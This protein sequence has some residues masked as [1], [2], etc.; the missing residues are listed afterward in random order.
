[1]VPSFI[2]IQDIQEI[3]LGNE[4]GNEFAFCT[5]IYFFGQ[6]LKRRQERKNKTTQ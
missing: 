2:E 5:V 1:M 4:L 3:N 6:G